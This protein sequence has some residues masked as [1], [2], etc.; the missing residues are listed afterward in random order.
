MRHIRQRFP[1]PLSPPWTSP[2]LLRV[3][4]ASTGTDIT[5]VGTGSHDVRG[6][7]FDPVN[8]TWY[9]GT[10]GDGSTSGTFGTVSFSGTTATLT[11]LLSNVPAHGLTF[12]PFTND[13]LFSSG[14][15]IA[16]FN[17][18]TGTIVSLVTLGLGNAFDQSSTDGHGHL[19]V[20]SNNGLL[21]GLDY[22]SATGHLIGNGTDGFAFLA[23][24]L[25]D[26]APLSGTGSHSAPEPATLA[27][28]ALGVAGLAASRR[29]K[30]S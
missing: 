13:I 14:D 8:N 2:Q 19:F 21:Y 3:V 26:V 15:E 7:I 29:R 17:P 16:Q 18:T 30:L 9:Y 25:D 28:L 6:L 4:D 1:F 12:D 23:V 10:A 11:P 5:V 27:L 20:A 24:A 22:D